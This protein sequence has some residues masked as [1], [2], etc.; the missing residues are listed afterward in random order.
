[1]KITVIREV[2][3]SQKRMTVCSA[4]TNGSAAKLTRCIRACHCVSNSIIICPHNNI[5]LIYNQWI[6]AEGGG[7]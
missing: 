5:A 3:S 6:S 4:C 7:P 2:T 1:M